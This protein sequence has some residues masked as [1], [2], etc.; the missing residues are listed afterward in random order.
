MHRQNKGFFEE[1]ISGKTTYLAE[2]L[3]DYNC[4]YQNL[5]NG[6]NG[7]ST[8]ILGRYSLS[9]AYDEV[10]FESLI[11]GLNMFLKRPDLYLDK[12]FVEFGYLLKNLS[13]KDEIIP[14]GVNLTSILDANLDLNN[15][16]KRD[17]SPIIN[18]TIYFDTKL[19]RHVLQS[20]ESK[21][22]RNGVELKLVVNN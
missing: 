15:F 16:F 11:M 17:I 8:Q 10:F 3:K 2:S 4:N 5:K 19:K 6:R 7:S 21:Y 14:V 13:A 9:Y 20:F 12:P 1:L 18:P 22:M